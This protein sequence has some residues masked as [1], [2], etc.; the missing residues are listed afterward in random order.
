MYA[1]TGEDRFREKVSRLARGF[2]ATIADDGYFYATELSRR[3]WG[4]YIYD[5]IATGLRDAYALAGERE[6]LSALDRI[7]RWMAL[8]DLRH[9]DEWFTLP[10]GLFA[11]YALTRDDRFMLLAQKLDYPEVN[12]AL[13]RG[14]DATLTGRHAYSHV[15]ALVS[16]ARTYEATGDRCH[17]QASL[18]GW[19]FLVGSQLYASGGWGPDEHL[20]E[21]HRGTLEASLGSTEAHFETLCGTYANLALDRYLLRWSGET[22][23]GDNMERLIQNASLAALPLEPDGKNF[24]YSSYAAGAK[25]AY[26]P[27]AWTCDAGTYPLVTAGYAQDIFFHD[28]DETLYVNLF[29]PSRV[30]WRR[31]DGDVTVDQTTEYPANGRTEIVIHTE[32]PKRFTLAVRVPGWANDDLRFDVAG[33]LLRAQPGGRTPF[34]MD[35]V[36]NDGERV[37]VTVPMSL[38][39]EPI[40]DEHADHAAL[41]IGPVLLVALATTELTLDVDPKRPEAAIVPSGRAPLTF[42]TLDGQVR[43]VPFQSLGPGEAYTTYVHLR[44][45]ADLN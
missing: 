17:R 10:E 16:A 25:K 11:S 7:T 39:F 14:D 31:K 36:W 9:T 18:I 43:F 21:P 33:E 32:V 26:H 1:E 42:A 45:V 38:R 3:I 41:M 24:Y 2:A 13:A 5:K 34:R 28:G 4:N 37:I 40:D 30:R 22:K 23:Y 15:N 6:A 29:V 12:C 8:Q 19:N 44:R 20:V 27:D 35:R